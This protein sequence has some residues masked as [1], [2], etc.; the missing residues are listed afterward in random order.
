MWGV[1]RGL[2]AVMVTGDSVMGVVYGVLLTRTCDMVQLWWLW[3]L[4]MV[5]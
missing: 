3:L 4:G 2:M 5:A 1:P